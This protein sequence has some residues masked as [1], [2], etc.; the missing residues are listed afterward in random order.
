[1]EG[2]QEAHATE[3]LLLASEH[4][5]GVQPALRL[6]WALLP[7][8]RGDDGRRGD[9]GGGGGRGVVAR[10]AVLDAAGL[11]GGGQHPRAVRVAAVVAESVRALAVLDGAV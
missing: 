6:R 8:R 4:G 5:S 9:G 1:E 7:C 10:A 2:E 3:R 11:L